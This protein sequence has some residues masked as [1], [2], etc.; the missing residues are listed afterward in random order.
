MNEIFSMTNSTKLIELDNKKYILRI[1]GKG[2]EKLINRHQEYEVYKTIQSFHISDEILFFDENSGV[3]IAKYIPDCHNC[4]PNDENDVRLAMQ[5]IRHLHSLK[6]TVDF[7]FDL[8]EKIKYYEVLMKR[9]K[10]RSYSQ[11]KNEI[12]GMLNYTS[13]Y[14]TDYCLCH[15]DPNQDNILINKDNEVKA[16]V[17][18]EYAAMQDPLLDV[19]MFV[20][21]A[22]YKK[23]QIDDTLKLYNKDFTLIDKLKYYAYI[24]AA[25]LLW[26]NWCEYKNQLGQYFGGIYEKSQYEYAKKYNEYAWRL[27]NDIHR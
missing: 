16:L 11:L 26:S 19:A 13:R 1:P 6:L 10:Y 21:Y 18:W 27:L 3:K 7:K 2:T 14:K 12:F 20:I 8:K 25:G 17:D 9:S 22:G 4:N 23:K 15:I 5:T 24:S